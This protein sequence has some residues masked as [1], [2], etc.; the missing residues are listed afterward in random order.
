[1]VKPK[2]SENLPLTAVPKCSLV[3]SCMSTLTIYE[4]GPEGD[5]LDLLRRFPHKGKSLTLNEAISGS[6]MSRHRATKA[7]ED[8][9]A[10]S[11]ER[12]LLTA[13]PRH[14][15]EREGD[16]T[17]YSVTPYAREYLA[18]KARVLEVGVFARLHA[19]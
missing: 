5:A 19:K 17:A 10:Y 18:W 11:G 2:N 3:P 6:G 12:A 7:L 15:P 4:G 13:E 1:M 8:L 16:D 9:I 14:N